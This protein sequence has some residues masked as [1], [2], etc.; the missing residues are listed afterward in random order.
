MIEM[1]LIRLCE[2]MCARIYAVGWWS[3][4]EFVLTACESISE[5]GVGSLVVKG[6]TV[7]ESD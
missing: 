6:E 4:K 1:D 2:R 7:E 5:P 3:A